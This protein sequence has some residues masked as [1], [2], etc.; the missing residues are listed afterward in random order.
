MNPINTPNNSNNN[1]SPSSNPTPFTPPPPGSLP[2]NLFPSATSTSSSPAMPP[3]ASTAPAPTPTSAYF[4]SNNNSGTNPPPPPPP[5]A[6]MQMGNQ[7]IPPSGPVPA[8]PTSVGG[9]P[10]LSGLNLGSSTVPAPTSPGIPATSSPAPFPGKDHSFAS[11]GA[12]AAGLNNTPVSCAPQQLQPSMVQGG[13]DATARV[14]VAPVHTHWFYKVKNKWMPLSKR[15]SVQLDCVLNSYEAATAKVGKT[16]TSSS[17]KDAALSYKT[18]IFGGRYEANVKEHVCYALYWEEEPMELMQGSWFLYI[19]GSSGVFPYDTNT[20]AEMERVFQKCFRSD[21]WG[22]KVTLKSGEIVVMHDYNV[23]THY[24]HAMELEQSAVED[25]TGGGDTNSKSLMVSRGFDYANVSNLPTD[26][27]VEIEQLFIVVHGIGSVCDAS[28]RNI[29][30]CV[31]DM[32]NLSVEMQNAHFPGTSGRAEFIPIEWHESLH[33]DHG[34]DSAIRKITLEGIPKLREFVND[35]ILD[36]LYFQ[37]PYYCQAIVDR[38]TSAANMLYKK[39]MKYNPNFKGTV[40]LIG[41]S[42]GSI[43]LFDIL[44]HQVC[45]ETG[46]DAFGNSAHPGSISGSNENLNG[47]A[48]GTSSPALSRTGSAKSLQ[49]GDE[50]SGSV[51]TPESK[52]SKL[53]ATKNKFLKKSAAK[54]SKQTTMVTDSSSGPGKGSANG[55]NY[56]SLEF[57]PQ[58]LYALGSPIGLFLTSRNVSGLDAKFQLP[59]CKNVFNIFHPY[60]PVAYRMEPLVDP[61][62]ADLS[63]F[64]IPHHKGRKRLHLEMIDKGKNLIQ[65]FNSW[66]VNSALIARDQLPESESSDKNGTGVQEQETSK[67]ELRCEALLNDYKRID[68][69]LQESPLEGMG[70]NEYL[71]SISSHL[72]YWRSEDTVLYI[73]NQSRLLSG[74]PVTAYRK[75]APDSSRPA[76]HEIR[77]I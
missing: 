2:A 42:L 61:K 46:C 12:R 24:A 66:F 40:S 64:L 44:S 56:P 69:V 53:S 77:A 68:C 14:G 20:A 63:P 38:V 21:R 3:P 28:F 59:T 54:K 29:V 32:R 17:G 39:F 43:I 10:L 4:A 22:E 60:D 45:P 41:H 47:F 37:S 34:A 48:S 62:M 65:S 52:S 58:A 30:E 50:Q 23:I 25:F 27:S 35:T 15:D 7:G 75:N 19:S 70:L 18:L 26:E 1:N 8:P 67:A 74:C 11:E 6:V 51:A 49:G 9:P 72:V 73:L 57:E 36:V 13:K 55:I 31:G 71:F 76:E 16:G 33:I 5:G